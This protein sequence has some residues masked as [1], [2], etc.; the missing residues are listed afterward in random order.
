MER[1]DTK[2]R[3][4]VMDLRDMATKDKEK[5]DGKE[6]MAEDTKDLRAKGKAHT[7]WTITDGISNRIMEIMAVHHRASR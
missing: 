2:D 4:K 5:E 3:A 7:D 1:T 6:I